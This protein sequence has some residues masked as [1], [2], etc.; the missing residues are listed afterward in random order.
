MNNIILG[1]NS[2]HADSSACIFVDGKLVAASEEERFNRIK[3]W[4]GFPIQS[5]QYCL[6]ESG[7][8]FNEI[9]D[10]TLSL[11]HI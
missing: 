8:S 5:I 6:E 11:I 3:H 4:S 7:V 9:S 10:I 1:I 2:D